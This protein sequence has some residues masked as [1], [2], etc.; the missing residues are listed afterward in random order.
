M[1]KKRYHDIS[2]MLKDL[3]DQEK[4]NKAMKSIETIM[5]FDPE[6]K[7]YTPESGKIA[8]EKAKQRALATGKTTYDTSGQRKYY[9][10][11]RA[12]IAEYKAKEQ[13]ER[14]NIRNLKKLNIK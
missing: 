3:L 13:E 1:S 9:E 5:N 10:D 11:C 12:R 14:A 2:E 6:K 8:R 4:H 7:V